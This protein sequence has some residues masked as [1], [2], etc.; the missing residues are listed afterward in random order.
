MNVL[1]RVDASGGR[2]LSLSGDA[3]YYA[4]Y[5]AICALEATMPRP[6]VR[7]VAAA[8]SNARTAAQGR[9]RTEARWQL[10]QILELHVQ[11]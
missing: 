7:R 2:C 8:A 3:V 5:A 4:A 9:H 1:F 6:G 10:Q 11:R